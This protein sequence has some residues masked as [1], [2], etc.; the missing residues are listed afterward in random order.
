MPNKGIT[1]GELVQQ[2]LYSIYKVRLDTGPSSE[3]RFHSKSHKFQE[4]VMEANQVLLEL[5]R[6]KDWNWLRD[7][8]EIGFAHPGPIPEFE[9]PE[10]VYKL[11]TDYGDAVRLHTHRGPVIQIPII[12]PNQGNRFQKAMYSPFNGE[13]NTPNTEQQAFIVGNILTFKRPFTRW[14]RGLLETDVI[15]WLEP[16]H[17]CDENCPDDCPEAY[18]KKVLTELPDI[19]W[20]IAR[21]ACKRAEGDPSVTERVQSLTDEAKIIMSSYRSDDSAGTVTDYWET[22]PLGGVEVF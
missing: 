5:Q 2:V 12:R 18:E 4:V 19:S 6:T 8:W 21:T 16:L 7:R 17:I 22:T 1:I 15:R 11:C 9:I 3:E 13:Y 10:P 14:E 20:I